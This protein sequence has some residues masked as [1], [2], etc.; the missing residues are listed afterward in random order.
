[1]NSLMELSSNSS[2]AHLKSPRGRDDNAEHG[3]G[4]RLYHWKNNVRTK[5]FVQVNLKPYL[6]EVSHAIK[7]QYPQQYLDR[8]AASQLMPKTSVHILTMAICIYIKILKL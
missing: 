5:N 3:K 8:S 4:D 2:S 7:T 6:M 1:M